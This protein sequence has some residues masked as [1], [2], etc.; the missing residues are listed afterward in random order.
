MHNYAEFTAL[1]YGQNLQTPII[2]CKV[3]GQQCIQVMYKGA[4]GFL[5][6]TSLFM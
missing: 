4:A 5:V 2:M 3:Q 1:S 6:H